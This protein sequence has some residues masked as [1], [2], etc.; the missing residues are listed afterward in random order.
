MAHPENS[1]H[2]PLIAARQWGL[3]E[4]VLTD[5]ALLEAKAAAGLAFALVEDFA[6]ALA[7]LP[8]ERPGRRL[9]ELLGRA[10]RRDAAFLARHPEALF[11][12]L[13]NV[14]WWHDRGGHGELSALLETWRR[15]K[16]RHDPGFA[17][18]R[19]LRPPLVPLDGP[20]LAAWPLPGTAGRVCLAFSAD[21]ERLAAHCTPRE[22]GA[23]PQAL[24]WDVTTGRP[25]G[26]PPLP[27]RDPLLSPDGRRV[28][29][30][31]SWDDPV[32][33]LDAESGREALALA[34][35]GDVIVCAAAFSPDGR[36]LAAGGYGEEGG[37]VL[38]VWEVEGGER[39]TAAY[40]SDSVWSVA[41][42]PDG[43]RLACGTSDAVEVRE[44]ATGAVVEALPGHEDVVTA[45][46]FAPDGRLLASAGSEGSVR[47]WA[48]GRPAPAH[49]EPPH[50][51]DVQDLAFSTD[52]KR[53]VTRSTNDTTWLWDAS[54]GQ[55][56]A[57]LFASTGVVME[58]GSALGS[59]F[60]DGRRVVS[61]AHSG[62]TWD[63][64]TGA[65]LGPVPETC[66]FY[67][68]SAVTFS[69]DGG[70][71][72]VASRQGSG[73]LRLFDTTTWATRRRF[74]GHADEVRALAFSPD[75]RSLIT[76]AADGGV[77]VWSVDDDAPRAALT[78]HSG[79]VTAVAFSADGRLAASAAADATV[80]VWDATT[81]AELARLAPADIG[82]WGRRASW[83]ADRSSAE[84]IYHA[85]DAVAFTPD[86]RSV[87]TLSEGDH[88]R[89]W[90]WRTGACTKA[91]RGAGD[92][93]AVA[94]GLA[95][96]ALVRDGEVVIEADDGG[97]AV[98]WFPCAA[99]TQ[100]GKR[101]AGL[102]L[103]TH[104]GGRIWAGAA[105]RYLYHF[106]LEGPAD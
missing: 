89:W 39:L 68:S 23:P 85:A 56:V 65:P 96:R 75:G 29:R 61:I 18:A 15:E 103:T 78:G 104:P 12:C 99:V 27:C 88:V 2:W 66:R 1:E 35:G 67:W 87:V 17:W 84:E 69:P 91:V 58:G 11:Q 4:A 28:V 101:A 105:G 5:P 81:G 90:D 86:G 59:V 72:A 14:G 30:T 41:F 57:C 106:A 32:L 10:V 16:E 100:F 73:E 42:S 47:L 3:L 60:S 20:L 21:G 31:G 55:A 46:A 97:G 26:G 62:G 6:A 7:A 64:A 77:R 37:G 19:S 43:R 79:F 22:E 98:A 45:V 53:L 49:T 83:S 93:R 95:R 63:A 70:L 51:D 54:T 74:A 25:S 36:R 71:L 82:E 80:R 48:L 38:L 52:G 102:R 34:T 33:L 24:L 13:W 92:F 94:A 50:P 76:G 44:A 8:P 9:V 40:P